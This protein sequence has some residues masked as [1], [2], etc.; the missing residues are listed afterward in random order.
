MYVF[1]GYHAICFITHHQL[2]VFIVGKTCNCDF[3]SNMPL[4]WP[5]SRTMHLSITFI[6]LT[7]RAPYR[8]GCIA[9]D[10]SSH[11][12]FYRSEFIIQSLFPHMTNAIIRSCTIT[13]FCYFKRCPGNASLILASR[14]VIDYVFKINVRS[15][16]SFREI[17]EF[18]A[19]KAHHSGDCDSNTFSEVF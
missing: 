15:P 12:A 16:R 2:E 5:T 14:T 3:S 7:D 8:Y 10:R 9:A 11:P 6:H 1:L 13:T 17:S 18:V 19:Y 4:R